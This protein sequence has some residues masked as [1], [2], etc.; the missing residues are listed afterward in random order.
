MSKLSEYLANNHGEYDAEVRNMIEDVINATQLTITGID[1]EIRAKRKMFLEHA[2]KGM[3]FTDEE[4]S[5][6]ANGTVPERKVTM[7][8]TVEVPRT[9]RIYVEVP[10]NAE[11][12]EVKKATM[13][14]IVCHGLGDDEID[15]DLD[16]PANDVRMS[17]DWDGAQYD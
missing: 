8:V 11:P 5:A 12:E 10:E 15:C 6:F 9:Y 17:I 7:P 2:F 1:R 13:E 4:I 3:N 16:E 14:Y